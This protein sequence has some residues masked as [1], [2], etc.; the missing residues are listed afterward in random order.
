MRFLL[1]LLLVILGDKTF[2]LLQDFFFVERL[3][4]FLLLDDLYNLVEFR[5]FLFLMAN[6]MA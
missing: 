3:T 6:L 1:S 5:Y 4:F 2:D